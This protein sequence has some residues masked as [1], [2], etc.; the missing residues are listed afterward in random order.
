MKKTKII[1]ATT[2]GVIALAVLA[3]AYLTWDAF[4]RRQ[5]ALEGDSDGTV[6]GIEV[7]AGRVR[8]LLSKKPYPSAAN[9][10][11]LERNARALETWRTE[12]RRLA[13]VGD[14]CEEESV[15]PAQFK[16]KIIR[17]SRNLIERPGN[18]EGHFMKPDFGFGPFKSY[19]GDVLPPKDQLA[20]LQRQWYDITTLCDMLAT[21]GVL[22]VL[23]LHV[24]EKKT[25]AAKP[26]VEP[27]SKSRSKKAA[28]ETENDC[29]PSVVTYTVTFLAN[30]A[31]F[32][33]IVR[34]LSSCQRFMVIDGFS[35]A[36][37]QDVLTERLGSSE[38]KE[39]SSSRRASRRRVA[40]EAKAAKDTKAAKD[41]KAA[42]E[43]EKRGGPAYD[44]AADSVLV[45]EL[46]VS[47]YDFRT[48][49]KAAEAKDGK[50]ASK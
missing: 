25:E 5:I 16:E 23:D 37:E 18:A 42:G 40:A 41:A 1:L 20:R 4:S 44:P 11:I 21:N 33:A 46:T 49:E 13:S 10:K 45:A 6:E 38:K 14:W 29:R 47:V 39:S 31:D 9:T 32:T 24:I 12:A 17:E 28:K 43:D 22:Q 34:Q 30:P 48:L 35:F 2:G 3:M 15:S 50:E 7:F 8:T 26:K 19:L 27:K 36:H